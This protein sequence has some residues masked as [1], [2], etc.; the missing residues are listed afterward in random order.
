VGLKRVLTPL[1]VFCDKKNRGDNTREQLRLFWCGFA[2]HSTTRCPKCLGEIRERTFYRLVDLLLYCVLYAGIAAGVALAFQLES[3]GWILGPA[4]IL[5]ALWCGL[6]VRGAR[7][8]MHCDNCEVFR[9]FGQ[10]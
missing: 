4:V 3:I 9:H 10:G 5:V 2:M 6:R 8:C 1:F 7:V